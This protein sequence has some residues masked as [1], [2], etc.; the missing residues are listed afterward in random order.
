MWGQDT[1]SDGMQ[2]QLDTRYT[3]YFEISPEQLAM[4][5]LT[6]QDA[7]EEINQDFLPSKEAK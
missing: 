5:M 2:Y 3:A 6:A 7:F 1:G 4:I